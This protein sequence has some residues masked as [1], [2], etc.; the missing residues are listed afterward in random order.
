MVLGNIAIVAAPTNLHTRFSL[1]KT[2]PKMVSIANA[3]IVV[4]RR[5]LFNGKK[6][7]S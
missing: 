7:R 3:K 1:V 4:V 2:L 5:G 6:T